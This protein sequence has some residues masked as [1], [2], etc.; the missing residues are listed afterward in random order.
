MASSSNASTETRY[1]DRTRTGNVLVPLTVALLGLTMIATGVWSFAD[2]ESFSSW[3]QFPVHLHYLHDLGAFQVGIGVTLL[4]A[5]LWRDGIAV[6]L[7]GFVTGN[8]LHVTSHLMD[9]HL[10][11]RATDW[12][13]IGSLSVLAAAA[14]L[15]RLRQL[16]SEPSS[17]AIGKLR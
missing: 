10:G 9:A 7:G 17:D 15:A 3:V 14:L 5:L 11:G 1:I 2:P 6:A 13:L 8:T 4:L 12:L 16:A